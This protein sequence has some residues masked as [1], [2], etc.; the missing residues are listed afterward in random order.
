MIRVHDEIDRKAI[1]KYK[2][3]PD[4]VLEKMIAEDEA[5]IQEELERVRKNKS[6]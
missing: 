5:K 1:N 3:L 6:R 2:E 4:D